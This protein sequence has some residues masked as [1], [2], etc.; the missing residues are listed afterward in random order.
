ML[1]ARLP[2]EDSA[3]T[4]YERAPLPLDKLNRA[5]PQRL[6]KLVQRMMAVRPAARPTMAAVAQALVAFLPAES[7]RYRRAV[8]VL[9]GAA[10]G[11]LS[12]V[13]IGGLLRARLPIRAAMKAR[14]LAVLKT[15]LRDSDPSVRELA[16]RALGQSRDL[17]QRAVLEPLIRDPHQPAQVTEE[18]A[19]AL[20]KVGAIDAHPALLEL[21]Q[22]HP[23]RGVQVAAAGALAQLQHPQGPEAL[24]RLLLTDDI[25][26]AATRYKLQAAL[27]LLD[28]GDTSGAA[29]LWA[30][31]ERGALAQKARVQALGRLAL[32]GDTRAQQLLSDSLTDERATT[33]EGR[34]YAAFSL[35]RLGQEAGWLHLRHVVSGSGPAQLLAQRLLASLGEPL[36][37]GPLRRLAAARSQ[38]DAARELAIATLADSGREDSLPLL[39]SVIEDR[40]ASV[41]LRIAAA[42]ATLQ[43]QAGERSQAAEQSLSWAVAALNSD[44]VAARELAV[45][46]LADLNTEP[47]MEKTIAPLGQALKD[48]ERT[49][50]TSAA[51]ALGRKPAR[52]ALP[53]LATALD[54]AEP[55]VRTVGMQSIGKVVTALK[56]R[57]DGGAGRLVLPR[58]RRQA[59]QEHLQDRVVAS[60]VLLQLGDSSQRETLRSGLVAEEP[61]VRQLALELGEPDRDALVKG[62]SDSDAAVRLAAAQ[63]LVAQGSPPAQVAAVLREAAARGDS[64]GLQAYGLLRQMGESV[65]PPPGLGSLLSSGDL[66]T[67]FAVIQVLPQL[68]PPPDEALRLLQIGLLDPAAVVRRRAAEVAAGYYRQTGEPRF[69][70][71]VRSLLNDPD[72]IVRAQVA[73]LA[74]ELNAVQLP[75][76]GPDERPPEPTAPRAPRPAEEPTAAPEVPSEPPPSAPAHGALLLEGDE[77]VRVRIDSGQPQPLGT[78]PLRLSP[79]RHRINYLGGFRDVQIRAGQTVRVHVPVTLVEQLLQDGRDAMARGE[80]DRA[81]ESFGRARRLLQRGKGNDTLRAELAYQQ[82]TLYEARG[83]LRE[84]LGEYNRCLSVPADER[85]AEVNKGLAAAMSRLSGKAG[86]IQ[87]FTNVGGACQM[88]QEVLLLPGEQIIGVGQGRT[89]TVFSQVGSTNRVMACQ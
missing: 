2:F 29:L 3:L 89:R 36:D 76:R 13:L 18:A 25:G 31:I 57:G 87:I 20:G 15:S 45:A 41:R 26:P 1:A 59:E 81:G 60:G 52:T 75:A 73:T 9:L 7:A 56:A 28:R 44:S 8:A 79:G 5:V 61:R 85:S 22:R 83:Q 70:Q 51:V 64:T 77:E 68:P 49:I 46:A 48:H 40:A 88:T 80:L 72:V 53:V 62:L 38:P 55:E 71:M 17:E 58:L 12:V 86:R 54:D 4:L 30:G 47:M 11:L 32:C 35:A 74:A 6:V 50:R 24:R 34:I 82:A 69:L 23:D 66:P 27:L 21:L 14:A 43:L 19:R 37:A 78:R 33:G 39:S 63:R 10:V 42:G 16:V 67:R 65:P 84:A